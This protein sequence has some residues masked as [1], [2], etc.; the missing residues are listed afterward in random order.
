[1]IDNTVPPYAGWLFKEIPKSPTEAISQF[2]F[3]RVLE[4]TK[5]ALQRHIRDYFDGKY[6]PLFQHIVK[7]APQFTTSQIPTSDPMQ[8]PVQLARYF[9]DFKERLPA[10]IIND[11]G[12]TYNPPG[13]RGGAEQ[14]RF[15]TA[16]NSSI[17]R[18]VN[19]MTIPVDF[20]CAALD[21]TTTSDL[22]MALELIF[23]PLRQET[24]SAVIRSD[25][26]GD[27]WE[28]R[29]PLQPTIGARIEGAITEDPKDKFYTQTISLDIQ[30]EDSVEIEVINQNSIDFLTT[31]MSIPLPAT[32]SLRAGY[33]LPSIQNQLIMTQAYS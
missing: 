8:I 3:A 24:S 28:V 1:M 27:Q 25:R 20:I 26:L 15:S 6:R 21:E 10:I 5:A 4:V 18:L 14:G 2:S 9:K 33:V 23:G 31:A 22:A 7:Y 16:R 29:L 19:T 30:W 12:A 11:T 17:F 13:L 32:I